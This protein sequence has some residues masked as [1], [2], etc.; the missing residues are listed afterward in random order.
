M[1]KCLSDLLVRKGNTIVAIV[2]KPIYCSTVA[3]QAHKAK[4]KPRTTSKRNRQ[5]HG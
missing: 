1:Q 2:S 3:T 5:P 4:A